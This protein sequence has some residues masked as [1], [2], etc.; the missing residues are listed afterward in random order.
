M[1]TKY[2]TRR[3]ALRVI[4]LASLACLA[5]PLSAFAGFNRASAFSGDARMPD[6]PASESDG[7]GGL[8]RRL[9]EQGLIDVQTVDFSLLVDLKYARKD[10]FMGENVYGDLRRCYLH[11]EPALMLKKAQGCLQARHSGFGLLLLDGVRPRSVQR[12]MWEIV[13][14]TPMQPYVANPDR[15]SMHN[16]G[17]AVDVTIARADGTLLDMGTGVDH[18]GVL[19]QPREEER[20]L[21]EGKLSTEQVA[22]RRLLRNVMVEAGFQPLAIEWWH[23]NAFDKEVTRRRYAIIE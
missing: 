12:R 4:G 5:Y 9:V 8:E 10:N 14:N 21:T 11:P 6:S 3:N 2:C 16:Y 17:A 1:S 7:S 18:F 19:A 15:G 20:F 23:F 22:N 13:R